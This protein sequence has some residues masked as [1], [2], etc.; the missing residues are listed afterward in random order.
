MLRLLN[1]C[2]IFSVIPAGFAT[3]DCDNMQCSLLSN[4]RD[5]EI[6][7][8]DGGGPMEIDEPGSD[9][10]ERKEKRKK[11]KAEK[12]KHKKDK[13]EKKEK[14]CGAVSAMH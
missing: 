13:K 2:S 6:E 1:H 3:I 7:A 5:S 8:A 4:C 9:K 12:K 11:D 14:R 10:K